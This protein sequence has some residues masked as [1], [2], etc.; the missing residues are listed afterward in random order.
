MRW[1]QWLPLLI[2][3]V[4]LGTNVALLG[5]VTR[6]DVRLESLQRRLLVLER[7]LWGEDRPRR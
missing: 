3:L 7:A 6:Q 4:L 5:H 2:F 1:R